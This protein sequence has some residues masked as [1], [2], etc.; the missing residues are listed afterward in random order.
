MKTYSRARQ[1]TASPDRV[2]SIWS[3]VSTWK[4]WNPNVASMQIA[5]AFQAGAHLVMN[6]REG[7]THQMLLKSMQ[8]GR[9]FEL[10]TRVIPGTRF[11]FF[12]EVKPA[13]GG[14]AISQG[15]QVGGP[16]G[17]LF[18]PMA[19][20]RVAATFGELLDGLAHTAEAH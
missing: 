19:G 4:D 6:T 9:S 2:W 5:G 8:P 13:A 16:L 18:G 20:D 10:E 11:T 12:C 15:L 17:P 7:R 1:T 3:D 14:S